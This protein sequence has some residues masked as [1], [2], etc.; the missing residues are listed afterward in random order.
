[1]GLS[2]EERRAMGARGRVYVRRFDWG[3]VAEQTLVLYRWILGR[4][5][6]PDTVCLD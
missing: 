2:D 4:G 6:C 3:Q 5:E 1:M